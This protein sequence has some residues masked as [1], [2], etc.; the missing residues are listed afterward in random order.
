MSGRRQPRSLRKRLVITAVAL[1]ALVCAVIGTVT[2]ISLHTYLYGQLDK[3]VRGAV[4]QSTGGPGPERQAQNLNFLAGPSRPGT[5]GALVESDGS[6]TEAAQ[7]V[8]DRDNPVVP[9]THAQ[10]TAL[11]SVPQDGGRTASACPDSATTGSPRSRAATP[12]SACP[13]PRCRT[14]SAPSSSSR[15]A[16]PRPVSSPRPSPAP[17]WSA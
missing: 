7:S 1:I 13:R 9:L 16:S 15:S 12:W 14:P 2:T 8:A 4:V 5:I 6:V 10:I 3:Q 11:E 17:P